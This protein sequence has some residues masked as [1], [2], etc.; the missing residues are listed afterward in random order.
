MS[1]RL[2]G[3]LGGVL[4]VTFTGRGY[5]E[6]GPTPVRRL[7]EAEQLISSGQ[8]DPAVSILQA[9]VADRHEDEAVAAQAQYRLG[10][11]FLYRE[12]SRAESELSKVIVD[13]PEHPRPANSARVRLLQLYAFVKRAE[14]VPALVD[15]VLAENA[16]GRASDELAAW[17]LLFRAHLNEDLSKTADADRDETEFLNRRQLAMRDYGLAMGR[18]ATT[19]PGRSATSRL[20]DM[21]CHRHQFLKDERAMGAAWLLP[22]RALLAYTLGGGDQPD[23]ASIRS[24]TRLADLAFRIRD[25]DEAIAWYRV[26][27]ILQR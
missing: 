24:L 10:D 9:L 17:A 13:F 21:L 25:Y 15:A 12:P 2:I 4:A 7:A 18:G 14:E 19:E 1:G 8:M 3:V 26:V 11:L 20:V 5:A 6:E 23:E 16:A 27:L 22:T